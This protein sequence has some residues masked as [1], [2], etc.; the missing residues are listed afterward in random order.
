MHTYHGVEL[1]DLL[2]CQPDVSSV[3]SIANV[4]SLLNSLRIPGEGD[5]GFSCKLLCGGKKA[6]VD[7][8]VHDDKVDVAIERVSKHLAGKARTWVAV[9]EGSEIS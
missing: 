3:Y 7:E 2:D 6:F 1:V 8:V 9:G 5:V 4:Y